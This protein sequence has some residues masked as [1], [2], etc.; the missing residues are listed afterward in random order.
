MMS[1][2]DIV[3]K[4]NNSVNV[5][6]SNNY[7]NLVERGIKLGKTV[8]NLD[9]K[10]SGTHWVGI[11][12]ST[13]YGFKAAE[14]K[15][16]K[17]VKIL[18]YHDSFGVIPPFHIKNTIIKYNPYVEQKNNEVNCGERAINFLRKN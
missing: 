7:K 17:E 5:M 13:L 16:K 18:D 15:G 6:N 3:E 1:D 12:P 14:D 2:Q 8:L 9:N 10:G 11:K 4:T